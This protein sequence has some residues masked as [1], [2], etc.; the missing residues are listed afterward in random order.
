MYS[1]LTKFTS[2]LIAMRLF[3][4]FG[5]YSPTSFANINDKKETRETY[6]YCIVLFAY[7]QVAYRHDEYKH[8]R[9]GRRKNLG[10]VG[11]FN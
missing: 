3:L 11:E 4:F 2:N 7:E 9:C 1:S 6:F 10:R 8:Q 5:S